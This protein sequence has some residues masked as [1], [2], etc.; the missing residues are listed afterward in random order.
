LS[1]LNAD[2]LGELERRAA[3]EEEARNRL[4]FLRALMNAIPNPIFYSDFTGRFVDCNDSFARTVLGCAREDVR[5][6]P[7]GDFP[8]VYPPD[9][10]AAVLRDDDELRHVGGTRY[11]EQT[12]RCADGVVR[13]FGVVKSV[14]GGGAAGEG[15]I[16]GVLTDLT[17]RRRAEDARRLLEQ[18]VEHSVGALLILDGECAIRYANP[19]FAAMT[20]WPRAEA[21]GRR[22]ADLGTG[23][24]DSGF[25]ALQAACEHGEAWNG[26]A[27]LRR[28]DGTSFEAECRLVPL[29]DGAGTAGNF[30]CTLE[31]VDG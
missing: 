11:G 14:F 21:L 15:G 27:T 24:R 10:A 2:Y 26:H 3:T 1:R 6:R 16:I 31:A 9:V 4:A 25:A 13:H 19:A 20:G 28:G 29:F 30:V 17:A 12:L 7:P 5:G 22:L 18:A 8:D 23:E